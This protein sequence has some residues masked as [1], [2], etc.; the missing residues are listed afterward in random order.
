MTYRELPDTVAALEGEVQRLWEEEDTFHKSLERRRGNPDFVFY[1][2]PPT[3]NGRPGVHHIMARTIKDLIARYRTMTGYHLTRIAGWDTHGLP[4]ELEAERQLGISGKPDIEKLGIAEFNRVCREN[5]FTYKDDWE[6]LSL[7]IAYWLDYD[8]AYITFSPEY[9]ESVWWA[10]SEIDRK[11]YLYRGYKIVPYCPRCGTGLSSHEVAQGYRTVAE[12]SVYIKFHLSDDPDDARVL[13][14]TT[15]P[16]TLPGN[17]ALAVGEDIDYVRVRI[18]A[19]AADAGDGSGGFPRGAESGEVLILAKSLLEDALRHPYEVVEEL[20][21]RD[22]VGL[23]YR[24]LFPGAVEGEG[25][26]AAWTILPAEFVTTEEGT[27][28]VHTAVMYGEDDFVLGTRVG[29][30]MQHTVDESGRFVDRVPGGLSGGHVKDEATEDAILAYLRDNDLLYRRQMYEHS[31]PHCWRCDSALLYM[32]RDSWYI[33]T[34]AVKD[35]LLANNA[36]VDWHPPEIGRGRMGEWLENNVDWALSRDRYWGTPLPIWECAEDPAHREVVGSYAELAARIGGL[37]EDFDPHRPEIDELTWSCREDGCAGAMVRVPQ[38][39]DAWFDSGSMPFAQWHYPFENKDEFE[40][41]FPADYIAEGL[42]QTRGWFYSLLAISTILF[43]Q[44][45][46]RSVVVNDMILDAEGQK[47]SKSRGNVADPWEAIGEFGADVARFYLMSSSNPWVPK[48]WD[49]AG[50]GEVDRKLFATLRNTYRFFALYANLANWRHESSSARAWA[51]RSTLDRWLLSRLDSLTLAMRDDLER[52]DLT[53]AARRI[54]TFVLDDLSN[55]YVRRSRDRFWATRPGQEDS[56][57]TVDAFATL[58][59]AL[60]SCAGLVAP[61][62]PFLSDWIHRALGDGASVHLSDY[63]ID[64]GRRDT[65]LEQEMEDVRELAALGRAAREHANIR[66][67]QPLR[68]L[69]AIVPGGR[70]ISPALTAILQ[71]ELNVH[72]VVFLSDSDEVVRLSAKPNFGALGPRFGPRT[73]AVAKAISALGGEAVRSLQAGEEATLAVDG[74]P[75]A[76]GPEHVTVLEEASGDLE[77]T[78]SDGY[79]V[80]LDRTIDEALR[81]EG[82]ARELVNRVQRLRKDAGLEVSDRILLGI[83]GA[84]AVE[85]AAEQHRAHIAGETLATELQIGAEGT[86]DLWNV[87]EVE[88]DGEWVTIGVARCGEQ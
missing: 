41:H 35:R 82:I 48:R 51:K 21:G 88:I 68:T 65:A 5:I 34:T 43:D 73:P 72:R 63:P 19:P 70:R 78:S 85:E 57:D 7:R 75:V 52:Y 36:A 25:N 11:G 27:G 28:V 26:E 37:P 62:A 32:A 46:Y 86:G 18:M 42:D 33:Q 24:P 2:G 9:V 10:I 79:L 14:W 53:I 15:T 69:G 74:Q 61:I 60:L 67:R 66:I 30:P 20:K 45:P 29:L 22:L 55:W 50:L 1:E 77:V 13:S 54:S 59:E 8:R 49:P 6:Q 3:A 71:D 23:S 58:R 83:R 40:R 56:E 84:P 31:Y 39:A 38:V 4:V 44:P 87:E 81:A 80:A 16:W 64:E 76:I 47:M 17:L 12:P